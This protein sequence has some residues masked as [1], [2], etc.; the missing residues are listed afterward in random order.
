[1]INTYGTGTPF[2]VR[3]AESG[4]RRVPGRHMDVTQRS[5]SYTCDKCGFTATHYV[6]AARELPPKVACGWSG[7]TGTRTP[8]ANARVK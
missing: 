3:F 1:V 4:H 2:Y 6:P 5:A 7:C 8:T